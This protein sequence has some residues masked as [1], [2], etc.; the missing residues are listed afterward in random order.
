MKEFLVSQD[1]DYV[2]GHLRYGHLQGIVEAES[3]EEAKAMF[4][5]RDTSM[6]DFVADDYEIEDY[7]VGDNPIEIKEIEL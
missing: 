4:S 2:V 5:D 3:L 7:S 1:C 6:L